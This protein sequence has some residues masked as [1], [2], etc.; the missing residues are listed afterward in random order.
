MPLNQNLEF[1]SAPEHVKKAFVGLPDK[2]WLKP[3][4]K[5]YKW[6]DHPLLGR[7]GRITEWWSFV[8][9]RTLPSGVIAEGFRDSETAAQ[10]V[11]VSH[12]QYQFVRAAVSE[13]FGNKLE[14]LLIIQLL[15]GAWGF[16]GVTSGQPEFKDPRLAN[17]FL[18]GGKGQL[19]LPNLTKADVQEIPSFG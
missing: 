4:T 8:I 11:G 13:K 17:V 6:T 19:W 1:S 15:K 5:L 12:R 2:V 18:I 16:A 9:R 7:E 10:R 14:N 3:G